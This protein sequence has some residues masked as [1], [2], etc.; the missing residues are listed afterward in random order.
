M[1][2]Q[3]QPTVAATRVFVRGLEVQVEIGI[4]PHELGAR[5]PLMV[6][7]EVEVDAHGWRH[8]A[9]TVNY[10]ILVAHA[11]AIPETGHIGLVESYARRLADAC[12]AE[13]RVLTARVR[14][15]KPRALAQW[16]AVA[17]VEVVAVRR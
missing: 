1:A 3:R 2:E 4:Y 11:L 15:E 8:L 14:V 7:I 17:G 12:V 6:D 16:G 13:P 10:E 9:D 5:Q